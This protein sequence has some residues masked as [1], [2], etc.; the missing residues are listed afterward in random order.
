VTHRVDVKLE[1]GVYTLTLNRPEKRNA[2]DV[3]MIDDLL[4]YLGQADLDREVRVIALRGAGKDFC[5]GMD[6]DDLLASADKS[7]DENRDSAQHFGSVFIKMREIPKPVV[8]V[9]HGRCLAGGLGLATGC[10]LVL[11]HPSAVFGYPEIQRGFVPAIVMAMLRRTMGEKLAFDLVATG[12]LLWAEEAA[13]L[14]LVSRMLSAE[15][16]EEEVHQALTQLATS[17]NTAM[18]LT[19]RQFYAIEGK[20]FADAIKLGADV[21]AVARSTPDFRKSIAQF[22]KK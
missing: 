16:F 19:K 15:K 2:I 21:N 11:A 9:V 18:A 14:A 4:S 1:D 13:K 7:L 5:A 8:A 12:R 22:L 17:S 20:A 3:A 10:D 6:L